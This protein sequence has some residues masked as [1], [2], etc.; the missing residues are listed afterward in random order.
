MTPEQRYLFDVTGYL[1]IKNA[2]T[3]DALK[4]TQKAVDNYIHMPLGERP[5]GFTTR[6]KELEPGKGGRYEHG[7]AFDRSLE[8]MTVHPAIWSLVKEFTF[9]MPR[10]VSG[11]LTLEQHNPDRQPSGANP[12]GLHCAREGRHWLTRYEVKNQQ[13]YCNDFVA[14]FYLTDVNPGDGGLIVIPGSHK[15]Q[16]ERPEDL[17]TPGSD[18]IDPEPDNVFTNL[19]PKAGDFLVISE[20]LTHGVLQWK[21][22]DRDRRF[23]ILRFR[24]QYE[25]RSGIPEPIFDRLSPEVQELTQTASYGHTKEV[26]KQD[27]VQLTA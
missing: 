25:G 9:D 19:T 26:V 5:E 17:L 15:S 13:I 24:P 21:P 20:L 11:T 4:E 12:G 6:P 8:A 1:H 22:K 3:G 2:V 23:L 27:V 10:F 7:F 14:F 16:F 18:G